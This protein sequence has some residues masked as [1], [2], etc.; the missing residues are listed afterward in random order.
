MWAS[1]FFQVIHGDVEAIGELTVT[2]ALPYGT[3][4]QDFG[5]DV[6]AVAATGDAIGFLTQPVTL[7]GP[8]FEQMSVGFK[9]LPALSGTKVSIARVGVGAQ[10]EVE[11]A[12]GQVYNSA[13][14]ALQTGSQG[15]IVTSGPGSMAG[16]STLSFTI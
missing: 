16:C 9:N 5:D 7:T 15:I 14:S 1:D 8:T 2:G 11:D 6:N 3:W 12:V 13:I 10:I 4:M